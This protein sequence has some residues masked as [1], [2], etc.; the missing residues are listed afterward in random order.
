MADEE[1]ADQLR[2]LGRG[3]TARVPAEVT[4]RVMADVYALPVR[5]GW[6]RRWMTAVGALLGALGVTVAVSA[7]V[8]A[9]LLDIFGF[10]G[11]EVH[12]GPGPTPATSPRLP[13]E[14]ATDLATAQAVVGFR[15][16]VPSLLGEPEAV[17]VADGRVVSLHYGPIRIDQFTGSPNGMWEK[18][19]EFAVRHAMV[20]D[21]EALWFD[22]PVTL[23]YVD[24][25]GFEHTSEARRTD[26]S[27]I[28]MDGD[29]TFR[30][31]GV[32]PL[33]AALTIAR[34]MT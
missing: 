34:S 30:L 33:E 16:Q 2:A 11:I 14:H 31:E 15:I 18:Y 32:R 12:T 28:W 19:A 4:D 10:G 6:W 22:G 21:H 9:G 24:I 25:H 29:V 17:T 8:R 3:F 23:V 27:L 26:G 1:L 7:P 13:G 20:D 5:R